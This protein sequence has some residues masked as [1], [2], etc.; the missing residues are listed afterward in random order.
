ML[1][2]GNGGMSP[3]EYKTHLSL[4]AMAA[5][6]LI[7]GNDVRNMDADTAAILL[8]KEVIAVDQ[9]TLGTAGKRVSTMGDVEVW[10]RPLAS[11]DF[12]VAVF[13]R[14][15]QAMDATFRWTPSGSVHRSQCVTCGHTPIAAQQARHFQD[16]SPHTA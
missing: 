4:W 1:E 8:N 7:A 13:N 15:N 9:D 10:K 6:P 11:G 2:I 14:G 12:A 5:A 3:D 16:L